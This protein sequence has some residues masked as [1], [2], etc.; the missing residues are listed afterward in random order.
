VL[1]NP[2]RVIKRGRELAAVL[3]KE[4]MS[5][6]ERAWLAQRG[7]SKKVQ[8]LPEGGKIVERKRSPPAWW[9]AF[10]LYGDGK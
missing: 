8:D 1:R 5:A 7:I 6:K 3:V 9:A 2:S 10:V 4:D